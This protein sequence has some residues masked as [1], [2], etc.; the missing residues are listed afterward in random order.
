MP[1]GWGRC[2][3]DKQTIINR[4]G[5]KDFYS[6]ELT[7][8]KWNGNGTGQA[9]CP[10]HDDTNPSLTVNHETGSFKCFGC[11]KKGSIFDWYMERQGVDYRTA[12]NALAKEAGLSQE[13]PKKIVKTYDYVDESGTLIFQT[14]RYEPKD[15]KQRRPDGNEGWIYNLQ[16]VQLVPYNLTEVIKA[17]SLIIVEG[18][19]DV[20]ALKGMGLVASCNAMGAEKWR[21]DYNG[22]F[23]G[24]KVAIIPD[25]DEKGREHAHQ[26][27]QNLQSVAVSVKVIELPGLPQKG[28]VSDYITQGGTKE[29]LLQLIKHAPEYE[30]SE[31]VQIGGGQ[32]DNTDFKPFSYLR[33]GSELGQLNITIE[34]AIDKLLPKQSITLLHGRGGI[35]KTWLSLILADAISRGNSFMGLATQKMECIFIDFENSLPVLV[36]RV[37]KANI[38]DV[39]FWHNSNEELKPPRLDNDTWEQYKKLPS[40]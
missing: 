33:R 22:Y 34:W 36:D 32:L 18:E 11:G 37:R 12:F 20:E 28:D 26:V 30:L 16:G 38:E 17:K 31:L 35:G 27:A 5:V 7:S 19:K 3:L 15:F 9:L 23:K 29:A 2:N 25:N 40:W 24:K 8:I 39:L 14:I 6:S 13:T 10:F 21:A 1:S 4:L